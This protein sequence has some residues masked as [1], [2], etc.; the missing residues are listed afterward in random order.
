MDLILFGMQGSGKGTLGKAL[1]KE[2][3]MSMYEAGEAMRTLAKED[4]PLGHK[5][6]GILES[7]NLVENEIVMETVKDFIDKADKNKAIIFDGIPRSVEQ[8]QSLMALLDSMGRE[9]RA[10]HLEIDEETALRRLT[11]RKMCKICNAIYPADYTKD[12]CEQKTETGLCG[13]E[14][15]TRSDD[16]PEAITKRIEIFKNSTIPGMNLFKDK[17]IVMDGRPPI[18]PVRMEAIKLLSNILK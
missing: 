14:L 17:L 16:V 10:F 3:G 13:G 18:E 12:T 2:F 11:T 15:Y 4:S 9:Y 8:A 6:K 7:G 5:I 1:A